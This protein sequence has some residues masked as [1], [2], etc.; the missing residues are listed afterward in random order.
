MIKNGFTVHF[1]DIRWKDG[2]N[3]L[4]KNKSFAGNIKNI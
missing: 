2:G 1:E 4:F 3:V